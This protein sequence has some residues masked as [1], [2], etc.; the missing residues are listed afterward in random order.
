MLELNINGRT[1]EIGDDVFIGAFSIILKGVRVGDGAVI[2][3]GS[4]VTK[5]IPSR[6]IWG[7]NPIRFLRKL[8]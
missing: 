3:A 5:D 6:E 2:G 7:G 8:D 4:V 1:V